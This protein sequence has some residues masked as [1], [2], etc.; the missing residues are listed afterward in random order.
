ML[1]HCDSAQISFDP[2]TAWSGAGTTAPGGVPLASSV[3]RTG[4]SRYSVS[5]LMAREIGLSVSRGWAMASLTARAARGADA[6][7]EDRA[8]GVGLDAQALERRGHGVGLPE[9]GDDRA[10]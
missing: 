6:F 8:G 2:G 4:H 7:T 1:D 5:P 3:S 10:G 9:P